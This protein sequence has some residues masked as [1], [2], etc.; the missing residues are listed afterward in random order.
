MD[1]WCIQ[2]GNYGASCDCDPCIHELVVNDDSFDHDFGCEQI[3]YY[4]CELC[5]ATHEDD[6]TIPE[7]VD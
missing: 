6:K 3:I 1:E 2:C 7:Y 4:S 5:G